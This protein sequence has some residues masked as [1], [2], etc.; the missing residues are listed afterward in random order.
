MQKTRNDQRTKELESDIVGH[1]DGSELLTSIETGL[2]T[3]G[4][5]SATVTVEDLGPVD[6]FHVGGRAATTE[7][8]ER[9]GVTHDDHILDVGCGIGGTT[10]FITELSGCEVTGV[11]LAPNYI[12]IARLLTEWTGLTDRA[13]YEIASALDMPFED[14]SFDKAVQLHVGMNIADKVALFRE[15]HRV[16]RPG[17]RFGVYDIM[18][19]TDGTIEFPVPWATDASMS[20]VEDLS[21]Y[22]NALELAG[23]ETAEI[24]NRRQFAVEFF[25]AMRANALAAGGPPPLGLHL[26]LGKDASTKL[27]NVIDAID[28][29]VIAPVEIICD[30]PEA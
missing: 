30:K 15:V 16:V 24:R 1:Y 27:A 29:G 20:F 23:F 28:A 7:L 8:C 17:G 3:I 10:R 12:T 26:I 11:D 14:S 6:E 25:G 22:G 13:G 2:A 18:R 9:L 5:S 21:T 19:V 4:K